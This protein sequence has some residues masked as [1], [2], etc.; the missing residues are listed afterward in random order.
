[1]RRL[2]LLLTL[3]PL[4]CYTPE[5]TAFDTVI[6]G[7]RIIDGTGAAWYH[8]D[9]GIRGDRIAR[10][11]PA[12]ILGPEDGAEV[13]DAEGLVVAPG[14][15]DI[16]SHSRG[17]LLNGDG[18][19][20]SKVTQGITTEILGENVTNAPANERTLAAAGVD[21]DP[22]ARDRIMRFSGPRGFDAWLQA[23]ED[24][25]MSVNAGS[26]VGAATIRV[27]AK[28]EAEGAATPAELDTMRAALSRAMQ[29]GAFGFATALIYPPGAFADTDELSAVAEAMA[30]YGGL[31]I[32]HMRSEADNLLPAIDEAIEIGRRAGVPV[33]IYHLKA[34]GRRN[35]HKAALAVAKIDSARAAGLDVQADMYPYTA[36]GTGL[37][38]AL[39]PWASAD[40]Q[41]MENLSDPEM[42]RRIRAEV[43]NPTSDWE[44]LAE[45][46]TPEGVLLAG[47]RN[48]ANKARWTGKRLS[49]AAAELDTDWIT[50]AMDLILSDS[51]R[52]GTIYFLMSEDNVAYQMQQPWMKFGT[53]AGGFDPDSATGLAHPRA[54]GTFP[55]ILGRYVREQGV[56][57]L[58]DAVRKMTSAVA[59]RIGLQDR[60]LLREGFFADIAVFNA[61][62]IIDHATFDAPHQLSTGVEH[63]LVN[64]TAVVRD[65]AHTGALP[66]RAVRGPG[67]SGR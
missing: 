2:L 33:E 60:G 48:E 11:L 14:F 67:W 36:G 51:S 64:G 50:A 24:H 18:R 25:G 59:T 20:V 9:V 38:A 53:D 23:M 43:L 3:A 10:I 13:I 26:F 41:L 15:I 29:D 47:F 65:G 8:G 52:V 17:D 4:G 56:M 1:M 58:E 62:T 46:A 49:E 7:G 16:Q 34:A 66:G 19:V 57:P 30:P 63:V 35:W 5:Q 54:Y 22:Q 37:T 12:G 45:L 42:R 61:D 32:T 31:Y 44:N 39:P 40:G 27:Y 28:G 55:R 6:L 21:H